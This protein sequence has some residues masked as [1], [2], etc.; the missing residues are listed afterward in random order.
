MQVMM[1]AKLVKIKR[2]RIDVAVC[3]FNCVTDLENF[4]S[5]LWECVCSYLHKRNVVETFAF[6]I[7]YCRHITDVEERQEIVSRLGWMLVF[8]PLEV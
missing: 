5:K 2:L 7:H 6:V 4:A 1:L 8:N 3:L